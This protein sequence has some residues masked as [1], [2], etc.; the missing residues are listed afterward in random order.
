M[1]TVTAHS[2]AENFW[3][4]KFI[5]PYHHPVQAKTESLPFE[6][7]Q[8]NLA[9]MYTFANVT[10]LETDVGIV[11]IDCGAQAYSSQI[12]ANLEKWS[13]KPIHTCIYTHGHVDH[14]M[15]II[16][17]EKKQKSQGRGEVRVISHENVPVRFERYKKTA[18]YNANIN[19]RQFQ[20]KS[21]FKWPME[22]RYP[23]IT[24][25]DSLELE[26]GGQKKEKLV[27]Y[28]DKGETDDSTWIW[29]PERKVICTGDLWIYACPNCGN[30][31][32]VQRYPVEW[33]AALKKMEALNAELLLP[34]HGP[35]ICG[36]GR[37][38]Q[39]LNETRRF[40]ESI[41]DHTLKGINAGKS[42][43]EIVHSLKLDESLLQRP[44]LRP[45]YDD[46]HFIVH[47]LWRL[48]CGW[49]DFNPAHLR[50]VENSVLGKE[51]CN[52]S[53]GI[54]R[55]VKRAQTLAA[56]KEP[57]Q[58]NLAVQLIEYALKADSKSK[59]AHEVACEIY[60]LKTDMEPS[61]MAK[62]IYRAALADSQKALEKLRSNL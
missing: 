55:I 59:I 21:A 33:A 39:A 58:L 31:Q 38:K 11:L 49:W 22:Y 1:A 37:V 12:H 25:R 47:N 9:F 6:N 18:D 27:L 2:M 53:G 24:Y 43:N 30:P 60:Q 20:G 19:T 7:F 44:Y 26:I 5:E 56:A 17:M 57:V 29:F 13:S 52:L 23:D 42:L 50:P 62:G 36:K 45:V 46:P 28:H 40:L 61:T 54:D 41:C 35:P 10:A 4:S 15:G 8:E 16:D 32:K 14:C 48:Y 51:I 3:N 34:G